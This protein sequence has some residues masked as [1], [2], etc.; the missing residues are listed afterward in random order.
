LVAFNATTLEQINSISITDFYQ[1]GLIATAPHNSSVATLISMES[2]IFADSRF[3]NPI[4]IPM[5]WSNNFTRI[6]ALTSDDRFFM[7]SG[8]LK[9]CSVFNALTGEKLFE[10]PF[11][12]IP[13]F[14]FTRLVTV[15]E[16]GRY[17]CASS[18][19]GIEI[20]EISGTSA[21]LIYTDTRY[22][23]SAMFVPSEPGKILFR[24][25]TDIELRQLPGFDIIQKIDVSAKGAVLCHIDPRSNNLL[26]Y[27]NDSLKVSNVNNLS[28]PLF[29]IRSDL[30]AAKMYNNRIFTFDGMY[31]DITPYMGK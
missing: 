16:D 12:Y 5:L 10:I 15:S 9:V 20:F 3:T 30:R 1:G 26:Y 14:F 29:K 17:F 8:N 7:V 27:Q 2:R 24:V 4:I 25:D 11:T 28:A 21:N 23:R 19:K 6:S 31:F 18:D 22:Y 13:A